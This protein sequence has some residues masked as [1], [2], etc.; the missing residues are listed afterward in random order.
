MLNARFTKRKAGLQVAGKRLTRWFLEKGKI[1]FTSSSERGLSYEPVVKLTAKVLFIL[2][3]HLGS[4]QETYDIHDRP[5][6]NRSA[7]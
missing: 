1:V 3:V 7:D 5:W 2:E 6:R 4:G